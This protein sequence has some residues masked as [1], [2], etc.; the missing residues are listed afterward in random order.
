MVS[1]ISTSRYLMI[2]GVFCRAH[3]SGLVASGC[4]SSPFEHCDIV[5]TTTHKSLRGP[6]AGMI[7]YRKD[8][9]GFENKINAA[10]FPGLQGVGEAM[11][12]R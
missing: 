11:T 4:Q 6:R 5:T 12:D 2:C 3:I 10:V 8:A 9:R 7:F 1:V